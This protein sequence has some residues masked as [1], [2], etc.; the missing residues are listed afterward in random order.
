MAVF[1]KA[2][3]LSFKEVVVP[4]PDNFE[5]LTA[6]GSV[7]GHSRKLV[8]IACYLPPNYDR[9][10]GNKALEYI[11]DTLVSMKRRFKDP[12]VI[13]AGDFN[14]WPM[15]TADLSDVCEV[16]V[17]NTRGSRCIDRVFSNVWRRVTESGTIAPLETEDEEARSSDHR[18]VYC[19]FELPRKEVFRWETYTYRCLLYTSPSPR[20][21]QKSRMPSSA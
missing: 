12:Y 6:V 9:V 15:D 16:D 13:L 11:V 4:N 5:V 14:Q 17:G 3:E 20:D 10:R 19:S 8:V 21:R 1:W 2:N 18:T 7:K